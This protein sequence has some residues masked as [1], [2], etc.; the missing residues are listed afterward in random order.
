MVVGDV[1][2]AI[3]VYTG[4]G[5]GRSC[6]CCSPSIL[7]DIIHVVVDAS[8]TLD[9]GCP[10]M[11]AVVAAVVVVAAGGGGWHRQWWVVNTVMRGCLL[12]NAG[13]G[14]HDLIIVTGDG[15]G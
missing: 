13:G 9:A 6:R 4:A 10:G 5:G 15:G 2:A 12:D 3:L 8:S 11:L 14:G 7:I 1:V